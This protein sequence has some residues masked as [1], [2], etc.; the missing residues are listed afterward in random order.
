MSIFSQCS[1]NL[2][3][4]TGYRTAGCEAAT[5]PI[6]EQ[7]RESRTMGVHIEGLSSPVA[8]VV[9]LVST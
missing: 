8:L 9:T 5:T 3:D 1:H 7:E 2:E 6:L 4:T